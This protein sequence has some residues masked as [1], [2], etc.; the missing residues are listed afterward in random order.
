MDPATFIRNR[1]TIAAWIAAP[2]VL[3]VL[4]Y[5]GSR[6]LCHSAEAQLVQDQTMMEIIPDLMNGLHRAQEALNQFSLKDAENIQDIGLFLNETSD[7]HGFQ[8]ISVQVSEK[9]TKPKRTDPLLTLRLEGNGTLL[10][11][12]RILEILQRPNFLVTVETASVQLN[13]GSQEEHPY[14]GRF[15]LHYYEVS[16][17]TLK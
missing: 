14:R 16:P 10:S 11:M 17:P 4:V 12:M 9:S 5:Q 13:S 3:I 15:V 8:L 2:L 7:E 6:L 1:T